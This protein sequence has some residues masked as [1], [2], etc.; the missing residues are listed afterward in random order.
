MYTTGKPDNAGGPLERSTYTWKPVYA[1]GL[2]VCTREARQSGRPR[3]KRRCSLFVVAEKF[4]PGPGHGPGRPR[5][6][7]AR[8]PPLKLPTPTHPHPPTHLPTLGSGDGVAETC[9]RMSVHKF[10][11][12]N[13]GGGADGQ[14]GVKPTWL[15]LE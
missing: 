15:E 1:G 12:Q 6:A 8:P 5:P 3:D 9:R 2:I 10:S 14:E 7:S 4:A 13:S 11:V